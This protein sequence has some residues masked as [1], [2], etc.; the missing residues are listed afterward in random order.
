MCSRPRA[1]PPQAVARRRSPYGRSPRTSRNPPRPGRNPAA[2]R[3]YPSRRSRRSPRRRSRTGKVARRRRPATGRRCRLARKTSR[4]A[5]QGRRLA[6]R[7]RQPAGRSHRP[8]PRSR[9]PAGRPYR[10]SR[11]RKW[12]WYSRQSQH[13]RSRQYALRPRLCRTWTAEPAASA[14]PSW[15]CFSSPSRHW[16]SCCNGCR[17]LEQAG[18]QGSCPAS[19]VAVARQ[20]L[21][22]YLLLP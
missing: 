1:D 11:H 10:S 14:W 22:E 8:V 17:R 21:E 2:G 12:R 15:C 20:G 9:R 6:G 16:F 19:V 18:Q 3:P 7:S 4:P 5:G 13:P